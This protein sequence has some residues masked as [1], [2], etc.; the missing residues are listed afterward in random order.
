[1]SGKR[2]P[3][4]GGSSTAPTS[5]EMSQE[6]FQSLLEK[7]KDVI[8]HA[9]TIDEAKIAV[10]K[11]LLALSI[12]HEKSVAIV[13]DYIHILRK[14]IQQRKDAEGNE[15]Q[16]RYMGLS[17]RIQNDIAPQL[18]SLNF[19]DSEKQSLRE[20]IE[21]FEIPDDNQA[22]TG[23]FYLR[24]W[25]G[26]FATNGILVKKDLP[27]LERIM[28][29][30]PKQSPEQAF[31]N[32]LRSS[33]KELWK[34]DQT[35]L[36]FLKS[37]PTLTPGIRFALSCLLAGT[38]LFSFFMARKSGKFPIKGA[39]AA[40]LLLYLNRNGTSNLSYLAT[41]SYEKITAGLRGTAEGERM[42]MQFGQAGNREAILQFT[43]R[44]H[45]RAGAPLN[46]PR[47]KDLPSREES[48]AEL[49]SALGFGTKERKILSNMRFNDIA[50]LA[51]KLQKFKPD[52][53]HIACTFKRRDIS[54]GDIRTIPMKELRGS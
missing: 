24:Q 34:M 38:S 37:T 8:P 2:F 26:R 53:L 3:E 46:D 12:S 44:E 31:L 25:N 47:I 4:S 36:T 13:N 21:H 28:G 50:E 18:S 51:A 54:I 41:S 32:E 6:L 39:I 35:N 42:L 30:K 52:E 40:G 15:V 22:K 11:L 45:I 16:I 19:T 5:S 27:I 23:Q 14:S 20:I 17:M 49:S 7:H 33:M 43:K 1:M 29:E 9:G 48:Y 10:Q